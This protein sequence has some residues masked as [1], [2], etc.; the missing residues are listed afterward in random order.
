MN[1]GRHL[2]HLINDILDIDVLENGK[3]QLQTENLS[4]KDVVQNTCNIVVINAE[5][6]NRHK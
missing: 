4:L 6:K 3:I 5:K 2:L 1:A